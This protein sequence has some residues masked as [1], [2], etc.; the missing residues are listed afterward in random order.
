MEDYE[1]ENVAE[2]GPVNG[3][4]ALKFLLKENRLTADDL[5]D[6]IGVNRSI[7]YRILK[8]ARNLTADLSKNSL[9]VSR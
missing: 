7:V 6:I 1:R 4:E 5:A 3:L 2:P 8:G 9:P